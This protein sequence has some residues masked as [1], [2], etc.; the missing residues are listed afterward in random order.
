MWLT[1]LVAVGVLIRVSLLIIKNTFFRN[2]RICTGYP[3]IQDSAYTDA[4]E[5]DL[6]LNNYL[7]E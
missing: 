3:K 5:G 2:E 4:K 1:G 7:E 6:R